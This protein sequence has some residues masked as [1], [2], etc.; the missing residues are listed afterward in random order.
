[1]ENIENT[2]DLLNQ[3][4]ALMAQEKY[5]SAIEKFSKAVDESPKEEECYINLGNAY[6]CV[7]KY[8]EALSNFK[9]A[10]LLNKDSV[11][12]M[13]SIGNI[14]YLQDDIVGALKYYNKADETKE[15]TADMYDV[16]ASM[17]ANEE[18]YVQALRFL[19]KAIKKDPLN[20]EL[21][22]EKADIFIKQNEVDEAIETLTELNQLM[23]EVY[24]AY[25]MLSQIYAIKGD[26]KKALDIVEKGINK[27]PEDGNL[28]YLKLKVY[29]S[30]EKNEEIIEY[31]KK[32]KEQKLYDE[33]VEDNSII[34]ANVY[35]RKNEIQKAIDI[36]EEAADGKYDNENIANVLLTIYIKYGNFKKVIEISEY[37]FKNEVTL[38][39]MASARFYHAKALK[40]LDEVER[41][42]EE[43][44]E[45]TKEFRRMTIIEPSF[46]EGYMYRLLSH[47]ELKEYDEALEISE[48]MAD[49]FP[50]RADG[51]IFKYIIYKDMGDKAK[52][53]EIEKKIKEVDPEFIL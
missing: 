3:G 25:D 28:A 44:K 5:E 21:Y 17:F 11:E 48:Y 6:S 35:L 29:D 37:I 41:A 53:E 43:F 23:P 14:L 40:E 19:N 47:N 7:N 24:A 8:D 50:E 1:M 18:D 38:F 26:Y 51:Y 30:F 4:S 49:L 16:V 36:L 46:Y 12:A 45:M 42:T 2:L 52:M 13:F 22:L 20:G 10:L 34:L 15:M 32:M 27:Y 9:K 33:Q 31:A 39:T